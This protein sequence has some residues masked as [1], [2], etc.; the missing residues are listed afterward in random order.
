MKKRKIVAA[1]L[2]AVLIMSAVIPAFA[3]N[4]T[5][6][7][8]GKYC[9]YVYCY[10]QWVN[11]YKVTLAGKKYIYQSRGCRPECTQCEYYGAWSD[12]Y[13]YVPAENE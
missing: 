7:H 11:E 1:V 10:T 2:L 8:C 6:P 12:Q 4:W 13:R 9:Q 3:M 5:C